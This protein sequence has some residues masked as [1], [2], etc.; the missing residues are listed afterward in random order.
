MDEEAPKREDQIAQREADRFNPAQRAATALKNKEDDLSPYAGAG[1][2]QAEAFANDPKNAEA[3]AGAKPATRFKYSPSQKSN[4]SKKKLSPFKAAMARSAV[5]FVLVILLGP[6]GFLLTFISNPLISIMENA[7]LTNDTRASFLQKRLVKVIDRKIKAATDKNI[8]NSIETVAG[9]LN[10]FPNKLLLELDKAGLKPIGTGDY[11]SGKGYSDKAPTHIQIKDTGEKI[12]IGDFAKAITNN[13]EIGKS[14]TKAF[15]TRFMA[16]SGKFI[17]RV[18]YEP[19]KISQRGGVIDESKK[20]T[21][22]GSV[23]A[24][25]KS[26]T[27]VEKEFSDSNV[28]KERLKPLLEDVLKKQATKATKTADPILLTGG[29]GCMAVNGPRTIASV[30]RGV[31]LARAV[32][33]ASDILLSPGSKIKAGDATDK[34]ANAAATTV[35][36]TDSN[37]KSALDSPILQSA[38]GINK[39]KVQL[40]AWVAAYSFMS[41]GLVQ[42]SMVAGA[43]SRP[44]CDAIMSP[45]AFAVSAAISAASAATGP[46]AAVYAAAKA[47]AWTL[48]KFKGAELAIDAVT[49]L[50]ATL[51]TLI[52]DKSGLGE[53]LVKLIQYNAKQGEDLGNYLGMALLAFFSDAG[54][55]SN[56]ATLTKDQAQS[57]KIAVTDPYRIA[58]EQNVQNT[59]SPFDTSSQYTFLGSIVS[60]LGYLNQGNINNFS[61]LLASISHIPALALASPQTMASAPI[62]DYSKECGFGT[63]KVALNAACT[64]Y[65]GMPVEYI[66]MPSNTAQDMVDSDAIDD[67]VSDI[68]QSIKPDS[69]LGLQ[70]AD[71][72]SGSIEV[73]DGCTVS[74]EKSAAGFVFATD[75]QVE[76][77]L[78][79]SDDDTSTQQAPPTQDSKSFTVASYNLC[80]EVNQP[81]PGQCK[82]PDEQAKINKR[83]T[84]AKVI[85]GSLG[86]PFDIVG[87][88]EVSVPTQ[89]AIIA[90]S[91]GTLDT[92]PTQ[93]PSSQG[94]AI[95]WNKTKFSLASSGRIGDVYSNEGSGPFGESSDR[96]FP[97]VE[98]KA[99]D[100]SIFVVSAHSPRKIYSNAAMKEK[101][102]AQKIL[103]WAQEKSSQGIVLITGDFNEHGGCGS[104]VYSTLTGGVLQHAHD[105]EAGKDA[106]KKCPSNNNAFIPFDHIYV[107]TNNSI[108]ASGWNWLENQ[109]KTGTDHGPAYVTLQIPSISGG[110]MAGSAGADGLGK[111][112]G[113][114][115]FSG[116][117][118]VAYVKWILAKHSSKYHGGTLGNGGWVTEGLGRLGYT[119]DH[120]PAVYSTVSFKKPNGSSNSAGHTAIVTAV[121]SDGS[122]WV[123]ESNYDNPG[124]Y[125]HRLVSASV[126]Q[127]STTTYAH[128]ED[129]WH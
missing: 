41:S 81:G 62:Y 92:F 52:L 65:T 60:R 10:S 116:G 121:N 94:R 117:S 28:M 5:A 100:K 84:E 75:L 110:E 90:G 57:F 55:K 126:A 3:L 1:I 113:P 38:L 14:V 40:G 112:L 86:T 2:G 98:L 80:H 67:N 85:M 74:D 114:Q 68:T 12:P 127:A 119:V 93:V 33:A 8:S 18:F 99:G 103:S 69:K 108:T 101:V 83:T 26:L 7:S 129:G 47:A 44:G 17:S 115:G 106:T 45:E 13:P 20:V 36:T 30:I 50:A 76:S 125:G 51:V 109:T 66:N 15:N 32:V 9:R 37:G 79:G 11:S 27:S 58:Y 56:E 89:K 104:N 73:L 88:Q 97:W 21:T 82:T 16:Y 91:N 22:P 105:L 87:A 25:V 46:G 63:S 48:I 122:I 53:E 128:T 39:N 24:E 124:N 120:T 31:L 123:D 102:N 42:G 43:A 19:K 70:L 4:P 95:F 107:S 64:P 61:S 34:E 54:L 77:M 118:C 29:M 71:C 6:I 72:A 96:A 111:T 35:T 59:L 78:D 49:P 23:E